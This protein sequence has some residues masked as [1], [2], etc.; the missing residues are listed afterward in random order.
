[1]GVIILVG[2]AGVP[3]S[4]REFPSVHA[5]L[6]SGHDILDYLSQKANPGEAS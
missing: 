6:S 1:M 4:V 5:V 3:Q 2:G